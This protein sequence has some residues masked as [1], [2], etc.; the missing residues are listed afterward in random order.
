MYRKLINLLLFLQIYVQNAG[1]VVN[2][3][4]QMNGEAKPLPQRPPRQTNYVPQPAPMVNSYTPQEPPPQ[5]PPQHTPQPKP[6]E[7]R[8]PRHRDD[9]VQ[10]RKRQ[11][12]R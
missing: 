2:N 10:V 6:Q 12:Q 7:P 9:T 8:V 4:P 11:R 5:A 3:K 1:G